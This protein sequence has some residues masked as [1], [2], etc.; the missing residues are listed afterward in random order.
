MGLH[1]GIY[2]CPQN[3]GIALEQ[4][5]ADEREMVKKSKNNY[6][7]CPWASYHK[8]HRPAPSFSRKIFK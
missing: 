8:I 3:L 6:R 1:H 2:T 5:I 4:I 7:H